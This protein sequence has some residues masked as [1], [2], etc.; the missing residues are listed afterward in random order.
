MI[1]A[2]DGPLI[3]VVAALV[4]LLTALALSRL[5]MHAKILPDNPNP[6][7]SH[8]RVTSRAGGVGIFLAW[9]VGMLIYGGFSGAPDAALTLAK[10]AG[11]SL[12]AFLV[13]LAD[14]KW[15]LSP[16]WK[17]AGQFA[18]AGLFIWA[19]APLEAAPLPF[20][21]DT[22]LAP[23]AGAALTILWI[24]GFM[25]AFNFMDGVNGIAAGSA[26][27]GLVAFCVVAAFAG[28]LA[29]GLIALLMAVACFGFLPAN[30]KHGRLFMGDSGSQAISFVIAALGVLAA[31]ETGGKVSP[32][33][34][35]L[36]FLPFIF[37]VAWTLAHR[38]LR[39]QSIL[40]AHREHLYQ[41]ILRQDH[42]HA[43]IAMIYMTLT[44]LSAAAA[45]FMLTLAPSEQWL[46]PAAMAALFAV[47]ATHVFSSAQ[48]AGLLAPAPSQPAED[49]AGAPTPGPQAAE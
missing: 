18:A 1:P 40:R 6:R 19:F 47:G 7:S 15:V 21:G 26:A 5:S 27:I 39:R 33:I 37:D 32:L 36:I 46:A 11:I 23:A 22:A 3:I 8:D 16:I 35:P 43:K 30:L 10:F 28:A 29:P 34:A 48:K 44:A 2:I 49:S 31:N 12:L 41:L 20:V 14:D 25:N 9:C 38:L 17:F 45:I 13:G 42:S 24:V 4:V